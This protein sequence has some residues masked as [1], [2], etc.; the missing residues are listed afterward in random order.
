[1]AEPICRGNCPHDRAAECA[2]DWVEHYRAIPIDELMTQYVER[3]M[4]GTATPALRKAA[5][6]RL[7]D[8]VDAVTWT[9]TPP[10]EESHP[11]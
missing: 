7:F 2:W 9:E 4:D 5:R 8:P 11:L 3:R 6:E 1:M 10:V